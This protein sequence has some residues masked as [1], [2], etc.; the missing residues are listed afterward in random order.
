MGFIT[1]NELHVPASEDGVPRPVYMLKS[2]DVCH[3]FWVPRLAGK[4]DLIPGRTNHMWFRSACVGISGH[5]RRGDQQALP[6]GPVRT[7][8][9]RPLGNARPG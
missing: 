6:R 2:A 4:T 7:P 1:A 5:T 3:S 8:R 9:A